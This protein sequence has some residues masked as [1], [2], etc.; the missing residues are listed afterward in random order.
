M[1]DAIALDRAPLPAGPRVSAPAGITAPV[2]TRSAAPGG[3]SPGKGW[4]AAARPGAR[5]RRAPASRHALGEGEGEAVDRGVVERRHVAL[6]DQRLGEAAARGLV[7]RRRARCPTT[8]AIR[9]RSSACAAPT[10]DPIAADRRSSPGQAQL[11]ARPGCSSR[12]KD[13]G[14]DGR[15]VVE[16]ELGQAQVRQRLVAWR[17]ATMRGVLA[18]RAAECRARGDAPP[19]WGGGSA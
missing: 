15:H 5:A 8:G 7:Q 12:C 18:R 2:S 16:V 19:A 10:R 11:M 14:G 9:C 17:A 3:S 13:E 1:V 6:A 4:P